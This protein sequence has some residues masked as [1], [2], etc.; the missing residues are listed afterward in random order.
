MRKKSLTK[1]VLQDAYWNMTSVVISR[2]GA[3]IFTILLARFLLPERFGIY[4][5]AMSVALIFITF[6]DMGINHTVIR[7]VSKELG[8]NNK[9]SANAH[10]KYI[11]KI[12]LFLATISAIFLMALSYPISIFIFKKDFLAIPLFILGFYIFIIA[13]EGFFTSLLY[14][15]NKVNY[16]SIKE[17][18]SQTL[19]I[20]LLLLVFFF[21]PEKYYVIGVI[22]ILSLTLLLTLIFGIYCSRKFLPFLFYKKT[23]VEIDKK[24]I[25][26]FLG[27]L[28]AGSLSL[29]FFSNIDSI[30]LG[31][32]LE[33]ISFVG[34]YRAAF[35]LVASIGG[36]ITFSSILIPAFAKVK[37]EDLQHIFDKAIKY[38]VIIIIPSAFGLAILGKYFIRAIY[39]YEYMG[40]SLPLIFLSFVLIETGLTAI[41]YSVFSARGKPEAYAKV[42]FISAILNIIFNYI[43]ISFLIGVSELWAVGGAAI[44]TLVSRY[45]YFIGLTFFL[46]KD[47]NIKFKKYFLIKPTIASVIMT[48][49]LMLILSKI[50][51]V[52][53]II[54]VLL[55]FIGI[56]VY[57][58]SLFL[59]GGISK[60]DMHLITEILPQKKTKLAIISHRGL[61]FSKKDSFGESTLEAFEKHL[62]QGFGIEFD[63]NFTKDSTVVY[64]D[65][66]LNRLTDGRDIRAFEE[67]STKELREIEK[68]NSIKEK[69][70]ELKEV[71]MLIKK[72]G[73]NLNALHIKGE[74]QTKEKLKIIG[75]ELK[76]HEEIFNKLLVFDLTPESAGYL[77]RQL[78]K[79]KTAISV[80]HE[81]DIKRYNKYVNKT[82]FSIDEAIKYK[83]IYDWAWMDE[84]DL[85]DKENNTKKLYTKENV[86]KLKDVGYEIAIV[87]PELHGGSPGLLGSEFHED[88]KNKEM[89]FKR[90][91]EIISLRPGAICT[92]YPEEI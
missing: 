34:F 17:V 23:N 65:K 2:I 73:S 11:L 86:E 61:N 81:Y 84:W 88:S 22:L 25:L 16:I 91:K 67:I 75:E 12:K 9:E 6:A 49:V 58:F 18:F 71:L 5:L 29:A 4:S 89:L 79:L 13:M 31:M 68:N 7:Y 90:I 38:S 78:P 54:G 48:G 74:H 44:A 50:V 51:D 47:L 66:N 45:F 82:L 46:N 33:D 42:M 8:E 3:L 83:N 37:K 35:A 20:L 15:A 43:L 21:L 64:H 36:L 10:F 87:S 24:A 85:L 19:R 69:I 56:V 70:P 26:V 59:M 72:S 62:D 27:Y 80:S 1:I 52:N 60:K 40:A 92:D 57:F 14:V 41:F 39:G 55:V 32:F 53:I 28:I 30:M 77:K 63:I 76:K